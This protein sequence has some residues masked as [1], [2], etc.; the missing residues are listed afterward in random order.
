MFRKT[1][2]IAAIAAI[3]APALADDFAVSW[4]PWELS[5]NTYR[6]QLLDRIDRQARQFCEVNARPTSLAM[7]A[8][9]DTCR[10][11]LVEA[12]VSQIDDV[13]LTQLHETGEGEPVRQAA[14]SE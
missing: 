14:S 4:E 1:L 9:A 11:A 8:E 2:I 7:R 6:A 13:R 5:T 12:T 10:E 3:S